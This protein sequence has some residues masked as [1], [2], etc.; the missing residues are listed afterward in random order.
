[1]KKGYTCSSFEKV[2]V[3]L[4]GRKPKDP[5][6][7]VMDVTEGKK[8][9]YKITK[10]SGVEI[11][12]DEFLPPEPKNKSKVA[13]LGKAE[14]PEPRVAVV[15]QTPEMQLQILFTDVDFKRQ[16]VRE[17]KLLLKQTMEAHP[18]WAKMKEDKAS[19]DQRY[20]V[21]RDSAVGEL[22]SDIGEM[23]DIEVELKKE[24]ERLRKDAVKLLVA[25][26]DIVLKGE[27]DREY[28]LEL[29]VKVVPREMTVVDGDAKKE[30]RQIG[31]RQTHL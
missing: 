13:V 10:Q 25:G 21:V 22:K 30:P 20:K 24:D 6:I 9:N 18:S 28:G 4:K 27:N 15:R 3:I 31:G 14:A 2:G 17:T 5:G 11:V 29:T 26:K 8:P 1:M 7:T 16:K 12:E 19:Y 23:H